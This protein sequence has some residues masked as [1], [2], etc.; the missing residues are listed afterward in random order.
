[1][2]RPRPDLGCSATGKENMFRLASCHH[3]AEHEYKKE[4]FTA[5][6]TDEVSNLQV[7]YVICRNMSK[8]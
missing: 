4:V 8:L 7:C 3:Q 2:R 6:I 5:A 1:M